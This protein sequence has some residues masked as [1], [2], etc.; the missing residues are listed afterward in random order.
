[1]SDSI[2]QL[3]AQPQTGAT[4]VTKA[5]Q[6]AQARGEQSELNALQQ[7]LVGSQF[8]GQEAAN[9]EA[10]G[11]A[12]RKE[13]LR[14]GIA[15]GG[16]QF[17]V[18][19]KQAIL[20]NPDD[21]QKLLGAFQGANVATLQQAGA[22]F[23]LAA[24]LTGEPRQQALE[25]IS[26]DLKGTA[27][28]DMVFRLASMPDGFEKD[29]EM[30]KTAMLVNNMR[31]ALDDPGVQ[32]EIEN[33]FREREITVKEGGLELRGGEGKTAEKRLALDQKSAAFIE[34]HGKVPPG[35]RRTADGGVE[36]IPGGKADVKRQ[37]KSKASELKA[38]NLRAKVTLVMDKVDTALKDVDFFT[39]G[40]PGALLGAI[41]G[42]RA[43]DLENT[44]DTIKANISFDT[45]Q[46]MRDAS[47]TGGAL[48]Q[49]SERELKQLERT[50]GSLS[51]SQ[52]KEQLRE[53]LLLVKS[54]YET[55]IHGP[56]AAVAAPGE[57]GST[58]QAMRF[59]A[60]GNPIQ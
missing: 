45:L 31:G 51:R 17:G 58:V 14:K 2:L 25:K 48:G 32:Q 59:D 19:F 7:Q 23:Q 35:H 20:D 18:S 37:E 38:K 30:I 55:I 6:A 44:I 47:P 11:V 46:A 36:P 54:Q 22:D 60:Q 5:V 15:G 53:N 43:R 16:P 56:T 29:K 40:I 13:T 33:A 4:D 8:A 24:R 10:A 52:S 3:I 50:I 12:G 57:L 49:V 42:S 9:V 34:K 26:R 1:M 28:A 41:P 21:G 39:T 27:V